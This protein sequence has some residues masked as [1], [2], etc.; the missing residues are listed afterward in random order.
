MHILFVH[1]SGSG[2][3]A[4]LI[5]SLVARGDEVTLITERPAPE[6]PGLRQLAYTV[7]DA[8]TQHPALAATDYHLRTGEAVAGLMARLGADDPPEVVIGHTGWGGLLFARD[9]LPDAA[10]LGYCEYYYRSSGSDFD[11]GAIEPIS[12]AERQRIRMRNAAQLV[13]LDGLDAAYA[14]TQWQRQQ[15]PAPYR[16]R[17]GVCHDGIDIASCRPDSQA[18]FTLPDGRELRPGAPVV[19]F[20]ARD[21][22]PYRGYPQ[23]MRAAARLAQDD[24]GLIFVVVGG[25]GP[26]YGRPR[27]DGRLWREAM[28]AET[29][30]AERVVHI[31]WLPHESLVRLFQVSAA[32]VYLTV[33]FVL[34]WSL[35]EAM[36][37]GCLVVAS[38]TPPVQEAIRDGVNGLLA[39]FDAPAILAQRIAEALRRPQ[40]MASLRRAARETVR[41]GYARELCVDRQIGWIHRLAG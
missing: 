30:L 27:E 41:A 3:F 15:Y 25:D 37:C 40:G 20:V 9:A 10:L 35:L 1:R 14:P 26:G 13:A 28:L 22:D 23:F 24:P 17:I 6:Q 39:P 4:A 8:S 21:L 18:R 19:T 7:G 2:Q 16:P 34:S 12:Q 31:P 32:H 33:P 11:F 36:A 38:D 29:E 5:A